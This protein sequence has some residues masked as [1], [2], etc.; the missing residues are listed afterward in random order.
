MSYWNHSLDIDDSIKDENLQRFCLLRSIRSYLKSIEPSSKQGAICST[1]MGSIS[2]FPRTEFPGNMSMVH[3][4]FTHF[5]K[6]LE[7][8]NVLFP[9]VCLFINIPSFNPQG[10]QISDRSPG[11]N[12][13]STCGMDLTMFTWTETQVTSVEASGV[14]E[15][16]WIPPQQL[17]TPSLKVTI[18]F[19]APRKWM[20]SRNHFLF[21]FLP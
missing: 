5:R 15:D 6:K 16:C 14:G 1:Q 21:G 13:I 10:P 4:H 17:V 11:G 20:V 12:L 3:P 7:Q 18:F 2:R 19:K 8:K 9:T